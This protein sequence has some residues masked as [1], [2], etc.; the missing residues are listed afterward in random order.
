MDTYRIVEAN[1][2]IMSNRVELC[3]DSDIISNCFTKYDHWKY[4]V[5]FNFHNHKVKYSSII[6]IDEGAASISHTFIVNFTAIP[7]YTDYLVDS[8][9]FVMNSPAMDNIV[10]ENMTFDKIKIYLLN[11]IVK[12]F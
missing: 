9:I 12:K 3:V 8:F 7:T 10:D 1:Y 2:I 5:T 4:Q 11:I 6:I